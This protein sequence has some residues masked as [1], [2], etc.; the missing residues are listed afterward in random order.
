MGVSWVGGGE[1]SMPLMPSQKWDGPSPPFLGKLGT[2][3]N[4]LM[5]P[6]PTG[7]PLNAF[8]AERGTISSARQRFAKSSS[9]GFLPACQLEMPGRQGGITR[10]GL[11]VWMALVDLTALCRL[12]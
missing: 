7:G 9:K 8:Q 11:R 5:R 4:W 10:V 3:F 2:N 1:S 6:V 12:T